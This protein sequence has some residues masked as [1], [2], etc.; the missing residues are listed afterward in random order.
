MT[1][2]PRWLAR[3]NAPLTSARSQGFWLGSHMMLP[4]DAPESWVNVFTAE[5]VK[6]SHLQRGTRLSLAD[7]FKNFP[8]AVLSGVSQSLQK[9]NPRA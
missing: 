7:V 2:V 6:A 3:S 4:G 1:V 8:V 9:T 5:T